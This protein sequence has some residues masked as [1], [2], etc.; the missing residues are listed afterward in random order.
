MGSGSSSST[1]SSPIYVSK[2]S[3]PSL[4]AIPLLPSSPVHPSAVTSSNSPAGTTTTTLL[5][6]QLFMLQPT[7]TGT[8]GA[9]GGCGGRGGSSS[10]NST[11]SVASATA[12]PVTTTSRLTT[13]EHR[14][15]PRA[16]GNDHSDK[17]LIESALTNTEKIVA[18][19]L[20]ANNQ[21]QVVL[22]ER[23]PNCFVVL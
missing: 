6:P 14:L 18:N 9:G 19:L 20:A 2:A 15:R 8:G 1:G 23:T 7:S 5:R 13:L 21:K 12:S 17:A 10:G 22:K 3:T 4:T 11:V 16:N